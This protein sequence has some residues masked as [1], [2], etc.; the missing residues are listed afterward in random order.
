[1]K[2]YTSGTENSKPQMFELLLAD[3]AHQNPT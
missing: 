2:L 1:M 3:I